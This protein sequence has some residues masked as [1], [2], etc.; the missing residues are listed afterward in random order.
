METMISVTMSLTNKGTTS[1][2]IIVPKGSLIAVNQQNA[3]NVVTAKEVAITL[4]P[5][6]TQQV[7]IPGY[8][9]NK[10]LQ[11]PHNAPGKLTPFQLDIPIHNQQ[12]VWQDLGNPNLSNT[13]LLRKL[14]I[15]IQN[16][17][18]THDK[19]RIIASDL[20]ITYDNLRGEV[21]NEKCYYLIEQCDE[22]NRLD[23]LLTLLHADFPR[24]PTFYDMLQQL[25]N[26]K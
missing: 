26:T 8:C 5:K 21:L 1:K 23:E 17:I 19:L 25:K 15:E 7:K 24:A 10:D 4:K 16:H 6:Q 22:E 14:R 18:H 20:G 3:Q 2:N 11:Y 13:S 12:Q 9:A